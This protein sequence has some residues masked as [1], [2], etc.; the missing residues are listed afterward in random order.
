M[1][2]YF[3]IWGYCDPTRVGY[4]TVGV[5]YY[6]E[7]PSVF[8]GIGSSEVYEVEIPDTFTQKEADA[9]GEKAISLMEKTNY[10]EP[11]FAVCEVIKKMPKNKQ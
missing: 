6:K 9:I 8:A 5:T 10:Y 3:S 2:L 11:R 7:K 4:D 1:K